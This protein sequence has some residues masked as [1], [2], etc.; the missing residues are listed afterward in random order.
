MLPNLFEYLV[1]AVRAE[2]SG[3]TLQSP[4]PVVGGGLAVVGSK[5]V[6]GGGAVG[7]GAGT[8]GG[9][10]A[11]VGAGAVG[12]G[13]AVGG[14]AVGGLTPGSSSGHEVASKMNPS[15][16]QSLKKMLPISIGA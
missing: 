6:V 7:S 8:V 12:G 5:P 13:P 1:G 10:L 14:G 4:L 11:V 3:Q 2:P 16:G 15:W 9:G